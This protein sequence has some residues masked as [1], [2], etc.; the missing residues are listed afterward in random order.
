MVPQ[1]AL[2]KLQLQC[3][4]R[5][6]CC[7]QIRQRLLRWSGKEKSSGKVGYSATE[8]EEVISSLVADKFIDDARFADAYVRDKARFSKWGSVKIAYNLKKLGVESS[9]V[10]A[11]LRN[12]AGCFGR[13]ELVELLKRKYGTIK[14]DEPWARKRE[15]LLRFALQRG[16]EYGQI[17][18]VINEFR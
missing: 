15:K 11:A 5:E 4:R 1:K 2:A 18:D 12:N 8:I 14:E 9:V 7:G 17:M 16:F 13:E 3:S 10:E 6:Y